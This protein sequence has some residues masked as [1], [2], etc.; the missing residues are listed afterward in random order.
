M[1]L[2][3]NFIL[4]KGKTNFDDFFQISLHN[5]VT[6]NVSLAPR[7]ICS[8]MNTFMIENQRPIQHEDRDSQNVQVVNI[9]P[10]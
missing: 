8:R 6:E 3:E 5:C 10:H 2:N 4:T 7:E 9:S 1:S